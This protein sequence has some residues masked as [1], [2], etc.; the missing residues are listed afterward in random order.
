MK[1]VNTTK[2]K[3][4]LTIATGNINP[5]VE[6]TTEESVIL[7]EIQNAIE[8]FEQYASEIH[9]HSSRNTLKGPGIK[10]YGLI[11]AT[12]DIAIENPQYAPGFFDIL[13]YKQAIHEIEAQRLMLL[14]AHKL[15]RIITECL[16]TSA[17]N[18]YSYALTYYN[19][20]KEASRPSA[21]MPGA[22][23]IYNRLKT[24]FNRTKRTTAEPTQ[25]QLKRD[26]NALLHGKR[27]GIITIENEH[28]K[29]IK[30]KHVVVDDTHKA[31]GEWKATES[32]EISE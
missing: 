28:D 20:V 31:K 8:K 7:G 16:N 26:F 3:N 15:V 6:I 4:D 30:G 25:K 13:G 9:Q 5:K 10:R 21:D 22:K 18:A 11:E 1:Q 17:D 23:E 14:E 19:A 2:T 24:F 29:V 27:D 32:G 12:I